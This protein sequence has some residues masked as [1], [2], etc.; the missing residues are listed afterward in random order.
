M[1]STNLV[2]NPP[3][4]YRLVHR[5]WMTK[6]CCSH[7]PQPRHLVFYRNRNFVP[8]NYPLKS[9]ILKIVKLMI[10]KSALIAIVVHLIRHK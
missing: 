5:V 2:D 8:S 9:T 6:T 7:S 4:R 1:D 3:L 10:R